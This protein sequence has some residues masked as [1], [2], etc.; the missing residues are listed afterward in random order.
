MIKDDTFWC[1]TLINIYY[2]TKGIKG[3]RFVC[4]WS[5]YLDALL[6]INYDL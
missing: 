4:V 5:G 6:D 3:S 2:V 1:L